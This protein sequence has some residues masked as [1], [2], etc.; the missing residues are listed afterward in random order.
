MV[1]V[2]RRA[3]QYHRHPRRGAAAAGYD[4]DRSADLHRRGSHRE[5]AA[6]GSPPPRRHQNGRRGMQRLLLQASPAGVPPPAAEACDCEHGHAVL[7]GCRGHRAR[8]Q[9]RAADYDCRRAAV[10]P[11]ADWY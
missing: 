2:G 8:A 9:R 3:G 7:V 5:A 6:R 1:V 10:S 4:C 11:A